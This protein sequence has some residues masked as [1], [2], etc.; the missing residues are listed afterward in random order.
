MGCDDNM[1]VQVYKFHVVA[2]GAIAVTTGRFSETSLPVL[3]GDLS[4]NGT[5]S[6]I[7]KC[8]YGPGTNTSCGRTED[9]G[10]VCQSK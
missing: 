3:I 8:R 7:L 9:A 1:C 4:C 10:I 2:A 6:S 5:E